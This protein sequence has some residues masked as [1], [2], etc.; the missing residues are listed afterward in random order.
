MSTV[1]GWMLVIGILVAVAVIARRTNRPPPIPP[2]LLLE[3]HSSSQL[4]SNPG[5]L[6]AFEN[7]IEV[8][9]WEKRRRFVRRVA[10]GQIAQVVTEDKSGLVAS[11]YTVHLQTT[12]GG[13]LSLRGLSAENTDRLTAFLSERTSGF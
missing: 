4:T 9:S 11:S 6:R 3:I 7:D 2:G 8:V 1:F 12:G 13:I 5:R 10:Y